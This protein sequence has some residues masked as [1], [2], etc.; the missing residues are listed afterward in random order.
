MLRV[1]AS[2]CY[3]HYVVGYDEDMISEP[4]YYAGAVLPILC[5][6]VF[7]AKTMYRLADVRSGE[8]TYMPA[9]EH[10][11]VELQSHFLQGRVEVYALDRI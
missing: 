4:S 6:R 9:E 3:Q 1:C 10:L 7:V 5:C 11:P 8:T 2:H